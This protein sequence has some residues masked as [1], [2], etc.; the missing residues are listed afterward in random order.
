MNQNPFTLINEADVTRLVT[1][2]DALE[3]VTNAHRALATGVA[4]NVVR[5]RARTATAALHVL[6]AASTELDLAGAK[7]YIAGRGGM[8]S[9]FLLYQISTCKLVAIIEANEL[10]RLRTAAASLLATSLLTPS[11]NGK[12]SIIGSGFQAIGAAEAFATQAQKLQI[13]EILIASRKLEKATQAAQQ[14]AAKF[15]NLSIKATSVEEAVASAEVIV[16]A[17]TSSQP[18]FEQNWLKH[19]KLICALGSNSLARV[20]IPARVVGASR[21][22]VVDTIPVAQA[23][24]GDLLAPVENGKLMWSDVAELGSV[25]INGLPTQTKTTGHFLFCSQG[26]AV[27]DLYLANAAL[28]SAELG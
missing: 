22:V 2:Q 1:P 20:E 18:V 17:T 21:L 16:T 11:I 25:L 27:Q 8:Q 19:T 4:T 28:K 26:L 9:H 7:V 6:E 10:G 24:A 14:V 15:Q 3:A 12:L 5:S 13:S 23:E